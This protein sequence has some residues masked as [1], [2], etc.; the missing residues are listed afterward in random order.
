MA[1]GGSVVVT[2]APRK[3]T[4]AF[5]L[6]MLPAQ[7]DPIEADSLP[8]G[9]QENYQVFRVR[10]SKCHTLEKPLNVHLSAEY[11]RRYI[12]KMQRRP[13]SGINQESG[14]KILEFLLYR[15]A[16]DLAPA[17]AQITDGGS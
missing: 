8:I 12:A 2:H 6:L 9:Q 17:P 10:C 5:L 14:S 11:W 13:G 16:R 15:E 1:Q 3:L 4:L 7:A